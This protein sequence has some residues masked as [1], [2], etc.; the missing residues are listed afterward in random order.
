MTMTRLN[1]VQLHGDELPEDCR[2]EPYPVIKAL[3]VRNA[4]SLRGIDNYLVSALLLDA[5]SGQQ[6]G[7]AGKSFDWQLAKNLT[8]S[9]PLILAGG[10]SP[11]N[12]AEAIRVV[13]PYAVDVSSGVEEQ[14]GR[15]DHKKIIEF[16]Q[17]VRKA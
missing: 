16:I 9:I 15:K 6:Y 3:P 11:D 2:L 8:G 7:G 12:V 10:L 5:W 17:Q 4:E 14:P 13:N 1:V